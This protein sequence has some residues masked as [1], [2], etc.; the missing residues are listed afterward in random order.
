MP[1]I[2]L[3]LTALATMSSQES[4]PEAARASGDRLAGAAFASRS[5]VIA[6]HGMAATSHP[7]ASQ[8]A[9]DVLKAGGSAVDA[10]IAANAVLALAE[11][12]GSGLGGDL[13]A[14]VW[15]PASKK[16]YGLNASGRSPRGLTLEK[17]RE[18]VG[19][20]G[21]IPSLGPLPVSVPGAASG[22]GA[23]HERFG[24][25]P[26]KDVLAPA[27]RYAQ[28][29][30]PI[31]QTIAYHWRTNVR[32]FERAEKEIGDLSGFRKTFLIDGR[33]PEEGDVFANPDLARTLT[34]IAEHGTDVFY[35][36]ELADRMDAYFRRV[37]CFLRK[38]DLA[39]HTADWVD[40]ISTTYRGVEVCELPPNGQGLAALQMLNLLEGFD[41]AKMG[42]GSAD[43]L[44][45]LVEAK[46]VAFADR[47]RLYADPAF[48]EAPLERLLSK[49]Y[50]AERRKLIDL[51]K[52][53]PSVEPGLPDG[54]DTIYLCTAD[55][56]GMMVSL[57]Q[58]NFR[59]MGS[60]L[61]PD[62]LGFGL[63]DRGELF[64][65]DEKHPNVY[66]PG[67]RPFHTIIPAF[68]LKEGKP[69]MAFGVMGGDLQPQGHVQIL[70]N[71]IDFGLGI[72]EAG[73]APRFEHTGSSEPTGAVMKDGGELHLEEGIGP[74]V[75]AE[76]E[77]RGHRITRGGYFGGYQAI[78]WDAERGIYLGATEM[79]KDGQ[80]CGY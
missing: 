2:A 68:A 14:M 5:A 15:D 80:V 63:Q 32:A 27:I 11:P 65:L 41:L 33:G 35:K 3:L 75:R 28:E 74:E 60:G 25:L 57:I 70:V 37:G 73:D 29:G 72:Q 53:L 58:S 6:R 12:T 22:W 67:K 38:E 62:G 77:K 21:K 16:L 20:R 79:R 69:W 34:A 13:F 42:R 18:L 54:G 50:A 45:V 17:L 39:Q 9:V 76:L 43:V 8:A 78:E 30:I 66:A 47:A 56:S 55:G 31:P 59:G 52:A 23:L 46:K 64:A 51:E 26:L 40:P 36:G 7:L 1:W 49:E 10:A 19:E 61:V 4:T 44:H 48:F 71:R 24:K